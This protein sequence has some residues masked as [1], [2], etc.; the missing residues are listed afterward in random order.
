MQVLPSQD[1]EQYIAE[2]RH[3]LNGVVGRGPDQVARGHAAAD[4]LWP[5]LVGGGWLDVGATSTG[6]P[7]VDTLEVARLWGRFLVPVPYLTSVMAR[8]WARTAELDDGQAYTVAVNVDAGS[9][10]PFGAWPEVRVINAPSRMGGTGNPGDGG[11]ETYAPALG[12][13]RYSSRGGGLSDAHRRE[14]AAVWAS[15]A[16]GGADTMFQECLAYAKTRT[17]Y[18]RVIGS[19]Q[20]VAHM[21]AEIHRDLEFGQSA[22]LAASAAGPEGWLAAQIA[23][24]FAVSALK[25]LVQIYGGI[26]FTW[27]LGLHWYLRQ[28][29]ALNEF[30]VSL[31]D[32]PA[33]MVSAP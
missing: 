30:V 11:L 2:L 26:G 18:G 5:E 6:S 10:V 7:V 22:T 17:A 21:L 4:R 14:L 12:I 3:L 16:L 20:A 27:E 1:C 23:S 25:R 31:C 24:E 28:A 8:R 19:F 13:V 9:L 29:V 32:A 15:E 33:W